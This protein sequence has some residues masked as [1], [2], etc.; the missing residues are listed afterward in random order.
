MKIIL[1][2]EV[3]CKAWEIMLAAHYK[4]EKNHGEVLQDQMDWYLDDLCKDEVDEFIEKEAPKQLDELW[5]ED[6]LKVLELSCEEYIKY[7][8]DGNAEDYYE[9]PEELTDEDIKN[10]YEM[11]KESILDDLED[12]KESIREELHEVSY[13]YFRAPEKLIVEYQGEIIQGFN[14]ESDK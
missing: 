5:T 6:E 8:R 9:N 4:W 1:E 7:I 3:E 11:L 10:D 14:K 2:S 12:K 13:Y